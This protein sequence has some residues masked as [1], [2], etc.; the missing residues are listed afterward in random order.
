MARLTRLPTTLT[1]ALLLAVA[2]TAPVASGDDFVNPKANIA[3]K[4][5]PQRRNGGEGMPPLPLPA[6]PLRRSE[7]KREPSP[8]A[9]VG[10]I[11]FPRGTV[12][13]AGRQWGTT[14]IDIE[15]WV[16]FTNGELGQ[17]YRYVGTD[18]ARFSYD[19]TELPILYFTG[20]QAMPDWDEATVAKLRQY[21][22]DGGTLV[23][24]SS[25]GRKEFNDSFRRQIARVFPDRDLAPIGPTHPIY[26]SYYDINAMRVR[27]GTDPWLTVP[28]AAGLLETVNIG[29]RAAVIFSPIDLSCGWNADANPIPGGILYDQNDALK[30]GSNIVT[31]CLAEYQ[32]GRFFDHQKVYHQ[33]TDATRD[34]LVLGQ[35]VHNGD[36]D[37]T[38]HGVP[39]LLKTIDQSTTLHVQF[40][41]VP[42]DLEKSDIYSYPVLFMTGQR[43]FEFSE[44]A[45]KRLRQYLDQGGTM[46]VDAAVGNQEF[47]DSF[48]A[49]M[50]LL[51]PDRPLTDVPADHPMFKFVFDESHVKLSPLAERLHPGIDAPQFK[52]IEVDG[53]WPVLYSPISLSAGWEQLPRAYNDGYSDADS[54]RLGVDLFMYVV[55]H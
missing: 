11:T 55:S 31:Y 51:Y 16:E 42:V 14:I 12:Q 5:A 19:P 17:K 7:K 3:P 44:A 27:K 13:L 34:Q 35:I 8:P 29:T 24:H 15:R 28:T 32:Y 20:W 37:P 22:M 10:N 38:P 53:Q 52:G 47:R 6:T 43:K 25:C 2:A 41:R 9:L 54:L 26:S 18:F 46:I 40:K 23:V 21:L 1:I 4:A 49:E 45:N 39:N 33:A 36:W 50:K 48:A 30:L